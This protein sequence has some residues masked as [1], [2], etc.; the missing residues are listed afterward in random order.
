[1]AETTVA[2][3]TPEFHIV[4]KRPGRRSPLAP[5][6]F[7]ITFAFAMAVC[8][9]PLWEAAETGHGVDDALL[10]VAGAALFAWFVLGRINRILSSA[11]APN[12]ERTAPDVEGS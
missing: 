9:L 2:G 8:G 6:R 1:M 3:D 11:P 10:R 4:V 7:A 5:Y 12:V